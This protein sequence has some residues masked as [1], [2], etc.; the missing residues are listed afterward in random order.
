MEVAINMIMNHQAQI[1]HYSS[2]SEM[3]AMARAMV[4]AISEGFPETE[5]YEPPHVLTAAANVLNIS[6]PMTTSERV[7]YNTYLY[8]TFWGLGYEDGDEM[9]TG[10]LE[11]A[12]SKQEEKTVSEKQSKKKIEEVFKEPEVVLSDGMK[13]REERAM[14]EAAEVAAAKEADRKEKEAVQKKKEAD[15]KKGEAD[16]KQKE[17]SKKQKEA[18]KKKR[19]ADMKQKEASEKQMEGDKKQKEASK[20]SKEAGKKQKEADKKQKE[21]SKSSKEAGKKQKEGDTKQKEANENNKEAG[22]KQMEGDKKQ[23]EAS[24]KGKEASE[25]Q[26]EGG[27]KQWE[28]K[29]QMEA[30]EKKREADKKEKEAASSA[31]VP[32]I[33]KE[34]P[35]KKAD[36]TVLEIPFWVS[37]TLKERIVRRLGEVAPP[38]T[39]R[40]TLVLGFLS[41]IK[42]QN[43][44]LMALPDCDCFAEYLVEPPLLNWLGPDDDCG[45]G[46]ASGYWGDC[47]SAFAACRAC[48]TTDCGPCEETPP[49]AQPLSSSKETQ[50]MSSSTNAESITSGNGAPTGSQSRAVPQGKKK[51]GGSGGGMKG[52]AGNKLLAEAYRLEAKAEKTKA[53]KSS[54]K[55]KASSRKEATQEDLDPTR[56]KGFVPDDMDESA[57]MAAATVVDKKKQKKAPPA[58]P[59]AI[60]P[61]ASPDGAYSSTAYAHIPPPPPPPPRLPPAPSSSA[62]L[63]SLFSTAAQK[64]DINVPAS[65]FTPSLIRSPIS[66]EETMAKRP[67][68]SCVS[69][70]PLRPPQSTCLDR[71]PLTTNYLFSFNPALANALQ[72]KAAVPAPAG[73]VAS[74]APSKLKQTS[75]QMC[76]KCHEA[77]KKLASSQMFVK[78][79]EAPKKVAC[80]HATTAHLSLCSTCAEDLK[81]GN[82][83]PVCSTPIDRW[84]SVYLNC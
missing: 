40:D 32:I 49:F 78:C 6:C 12:S 25:K 55:K 17:A 69:S 33:P 16:K 24:K 8:N 53:G 29:K 10:G 74:A 80:V 39:D 13:L 14:R 52:A 18:E 22:K 28:P 67:P 83:C 48:E 58:P 31:P 62:A 43:D 68:Q 73:P 51:G 75:S 41:A 84:I 56:A 19:E 60:P 23:K 2:P 65:P 3:R 79:H 57:W 26:K 21:A 76:V 50:S 81:V 77:P 54:R 27:K 71:D 70:P 36:L 72:H 1:N 11:G 5:R 66:R 47:I 46:G 82:P 44:I 42:G 34:M 45:D 38:G 30:S 15:K 20:S 37:E 9:S 64:L 63:F 7:Q 35:F 59:S 61:Y 4:A